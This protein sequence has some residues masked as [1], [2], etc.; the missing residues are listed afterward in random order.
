MPL[1]RFRRQCEQ[2]LQFER[3]RILDMMEAGWSARRVAP[4]F[5]HSDCVVRRC[6]D[7]WILEVSL[8]RRLC[9]G[10]PQQTSRREDCHIVINAA[11]CFIGRDPGT[12]SIFIRV[13]CVFS[14]HAKAP[15]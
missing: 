9:S 4:Q 1:C 15:S 14:N 8:T 5:G 6:L 11:S 13:P 2:W 10:R 12:G 3:G 7:Q